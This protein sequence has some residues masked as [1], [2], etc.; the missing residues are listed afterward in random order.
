MGLQLLGMAIDDIAAGRV[1]KRPQDETL[2]TWEPALNRLS[3]S[4]ARQ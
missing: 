3:L 2:A 1:V 4:K